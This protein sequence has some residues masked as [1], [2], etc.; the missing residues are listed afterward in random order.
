[1]RK[2]KLDQYVNIQLLNV[3]YIVVFFVNLDPYLCH[4]RD[5]N[6]NFMC[7]SILVYVNDG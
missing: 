3:S 7:S 4:F 5:N 6:E 2:S 1:M